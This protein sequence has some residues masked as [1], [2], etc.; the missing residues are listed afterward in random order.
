MMQTIKKEVH[1][2]SDEQRRHL[3]ISRERLQL[4]SGLEDDFGHEQDYSIEPNLQKTRTL[5][6]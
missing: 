3:E 6:A 4:V 1:T 5:P 2:S